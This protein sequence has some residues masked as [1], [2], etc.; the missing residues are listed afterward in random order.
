[1]DWQLIPAS[2]AGKRFSAKDP[3][4]PFVPLVQIA[5]WI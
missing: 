2:Q 4:Q 1:M 5:G 3:R